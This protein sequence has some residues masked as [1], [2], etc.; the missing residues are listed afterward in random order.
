MKKKEYLSLRLAE[1][2]ADIRKDVCALI[3]YHGGVIL[4]RTRITIDS[5][6]TVGRRDPGLRRNGRDIYSFINTS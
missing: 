6:T 5:R 1:Y 2:L 3:Q 4:Y